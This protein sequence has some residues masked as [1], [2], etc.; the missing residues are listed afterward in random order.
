[1]NKLRIKRNI[2]VMSLA[3]F[4]LS[5]LIFAASGC[6]A[7]AK[8]SKDNAQVSYSPMKIGYIDADRLL[9]ERDEWKKFSRKKGQETVRLM[10]KY[11][12]KEEPS[13]EEK[14]KIAKTTEQF[15]EEENKIIENFV[16]ETRN[17]SKEVAKEKKLDLI[18][19]N[20]SLSPIIEFGGTDVTEDVRK[21][22][23]GKNG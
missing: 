2:I 10:E 22:L 6:Q 17:A 23:N 20:S 4:M 13:L 3:L 8:N 1:M 15:I 21:K 5:G 7:N 16:E 9:S 19:I 11:K 14:K 12:D 18:I